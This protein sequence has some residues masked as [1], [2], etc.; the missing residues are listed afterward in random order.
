M[1]NENT[2][3]RLKLTQFPCP[4]TLIHPALLLVGPYLHQYREDDGIA[5]CQVF[6]NEAELE[7]ELQLESLRQTLH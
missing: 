6:V 1:I 3:L 5:F 7:C 4:L 2:D